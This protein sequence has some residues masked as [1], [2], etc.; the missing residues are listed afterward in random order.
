MVI[1]LRSSAR[2]PT[3][4]DRQPTTMGPA[5]FEPDQPFLTLT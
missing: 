4:D 2:K 3:A 1:G 5:L